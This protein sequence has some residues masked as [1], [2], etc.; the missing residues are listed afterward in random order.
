[1]GFLKASVRSRAIS[2]T[3]LPSMLA[4]HASRKRSARL[5]L[6]TSED[7]YMIA[8]LVLDPCLQL[9]AVVRGRLSK[10]D[11]A[12]TYAVTAKA[13]ARWGSASGSREAP[14]CS[15]VSLPCSQTAREGSDRIAGEWARARGVELLV[16]PADWSA[17]AD[18]P[19]SSATNECCARVSPT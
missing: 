4:W 1:M 10:A 11:T 8:C 14:A 13:V 15:T 2:S 17:K 16:F 7:T 6:M 5:L 18:M 3:Q 9:Q 12:R 19:R